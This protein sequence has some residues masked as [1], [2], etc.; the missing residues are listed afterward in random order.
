ME[1]RTMAMSRKEIGL[2]VKAIAQYAS[3]CSGNGDYLEMDNAFK[4]ALN[5]A[6]MY[7][8]KEEDWILN[9]YGAY[10]SEAIGELE[11]EMA[12]GKRAQDIFNEL[13]R[14]R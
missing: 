4:I 12:E 5:M 9:T 10:L 2:A 14:Q 6:N 8:L 1:V 3:N 13:S 11:R 7:E